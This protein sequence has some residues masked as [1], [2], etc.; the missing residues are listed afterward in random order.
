M[1]DEGLFSGLKFTDVF[2]PAAGAVA[3]MYNPYI[4]RGLQT[5]M[6]LFNTMASFKNS[7]QYYKHL[8]EQQERLDAAG[9]LAAEGIDTYLGP[10]R[11]KAEGMAGS[12]RFSKAIGPLLDEGETSKFTMF[13]DEGPELPDP[14]QQMTFRQA[15]GLEEVETESP[16]D[17]DLAIEAVQNPRFSEMNVEQFAAT[18][19]EKAELEALQ[20]QIRFMELQKSFIQAAPGAALNQAGLAG[21]RGLDTRFRDVERMKDLKSVLEQQ[22]A[23]HELAL[24]EKQ[25]AHRNV[26]EEAEDRWNKREAEHQLNLEYLQEQDRLYN[27]ENTASSQEVASAMRQIYSAYIASNKPD[28]PEANRAASAERAIALSLG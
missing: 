22:Q 23:G 26:L 7:A 15:L 10:M 21:Y 9:Q 16:Q 19:E 27:D 4:G 3:S 1:A 25:A 18:E 24:L 6:N 8:K 14:N 20:E 12:Q 2:I 5:G 11:E 28:E 13:K 17:F